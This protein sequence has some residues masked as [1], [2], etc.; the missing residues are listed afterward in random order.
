MKRGK[1][2]S[3]VEIIIAATIL[4]I[5]MAPIFGLMGSSHKSVMKSADELRAA[6]LAIEIL[7]Q[8]E[9]LYKGKKIKDL[10]E[11]KIIDNSSINSEQPID[12]LNGVK[13]GYFEDVNSYF[14]PKLTLNKIQ[15]TFIPPEVGSIIEVTIEYVTKENKNPREK[16]KFIIRGFVSAIK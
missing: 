9:I 12:G 13:S 3:L 5:S 1:G 4:V 14:N 16:P 6:Q 2:I 15:P 11:G 7:D 10:N 8:I